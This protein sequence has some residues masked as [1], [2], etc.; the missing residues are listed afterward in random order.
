M[1]ALLNVALQPHRRW[2]S[3]G[4]MA[5]STMNRLPWRL[6]L[7]SYNEGGSLDED[8]SLQKR[9]RACRGIAKATP[10]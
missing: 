1:P 5:F 8:G 9:R 6:V 2:D 7:R 4:D 10:G 3:T